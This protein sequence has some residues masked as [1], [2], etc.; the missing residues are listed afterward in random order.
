[1]ARTKQATPLRREVSSEYFDRTTVMANGHNMQ[2]N[3]LLQPVAT[4]IPTKQAGMKELVL[5]VGGIYAS[6]YV[7]PSLLDF[8]SHSHIMLTTRSLSWALLQERIT[9]TP[10]GPDSAPEK[11]QFPVV[12]NTIQSA[13]AAL[14]GYIYLVMTSSSRPSIFP[15]RDALA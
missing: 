11:W 10:Y 5:C 2:A 7:C 9:T 14:V 8:H 12:L 1:M 15:S 4:A 3:G 6:L 13:L